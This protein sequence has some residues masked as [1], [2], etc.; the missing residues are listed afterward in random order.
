MRIQMIH[1]I[2]ISE[3]I[4]SKHARIFPLSRSIKAYRLSRTPTLTINL[5]LA[6]TLPLIILKAWHVSYLLSCQETKISAMDEI[7]M[8]T[9][10]DV[11]KLMTL[12]RILP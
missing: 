2:I 3:R 4:Y 1:G 10:I 12:K 7:S 8:E 9:T 6:L 11:I 5:A